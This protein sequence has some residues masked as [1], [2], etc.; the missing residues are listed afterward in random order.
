MKQ[1][2]IEGFS[3]I[4]ASNTRRKVLLALED[5]ILMPSEISKIIN[6]SPPHTSRALRDLENKDLIIC[7]NP[8]IR[9]GKLFILTEFGKEVLKCVKKYIK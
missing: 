7:L 9:V 5:N 2:T 1:K 4:K 3:Y 6:V 8:K